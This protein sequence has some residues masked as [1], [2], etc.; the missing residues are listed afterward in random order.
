MDLLFKT[1]ARYSLDH[2]ESFVIR[3][4]DATKIFFPKIDNSRKKKKNSLEK[5]MDEPI[6]EPFRNFLQTM[7]A[8]PDVGF[9]FLFYD[10]NRKKLNEF[11][12]MHNELKPI[13]EFL[14]LLEVNK[15]NLKDN[16]K[17]FV[18]VNKTL[19][20]NFWFQLFS[21]GQAKKREAMIGRI[22]DFER[23]YFDYDNPPTN[24]VDSIELFEYAKKINETSQAIA[25]SNDR[26]CASS[27]TFH[28]SVLLNDEI[29]D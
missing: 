27:F 28:A 15:N 22:L 18:N 8:I 29:M 10:R 14:K 11:A 7:I 9:E 24:F 12:N 1:K 4:F 23:K 13:N 3:L 2:V 25:Y 5:F 16:P 17:K 6:K 21:K 19:H 20:Q 26:E